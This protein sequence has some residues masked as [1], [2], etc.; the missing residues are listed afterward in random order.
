[1]AYDEQ[2]NQEVAWGVCNPFASLLS[3]PAKHPNRRR[4]A[5]GFAIV[6]ANRDTGV[7]GRRSGTRENVRR[8]AES[9]VSNLN[10]HARSGHSLWAPRRG[11]KAS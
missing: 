5:S 6:I 7:M 1:L 10:Q 8:H 9:V 3:N 2:C 4:R 11:K